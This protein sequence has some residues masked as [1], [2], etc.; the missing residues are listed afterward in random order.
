LVT[1]WQAFAQRVSDPAR[2]WLRVSLHAGTTSAHS[3]YLEVLKGQSDPA[4]GSVI[5]W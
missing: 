5:V 4:I 3:A 1:S 2:P